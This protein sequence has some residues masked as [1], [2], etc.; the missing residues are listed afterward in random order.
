M[1]YMIYDVTS[2]FRSMGKRVN[3]IE[4]K[5]TTKEQ[6]HGL[7]VIGMSRQVMISYIQMD[8]ILHLLS[9]IHILSR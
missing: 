2:A 9:V 7:H 3:R 8:I 6:L 4:E 1:I 5:K